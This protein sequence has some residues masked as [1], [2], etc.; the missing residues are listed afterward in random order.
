[1]PRKRPAI[2][3]SRN[4]FLSYQIQWQDFNIIITAYNGDQV[5]ELQPGMAGGNK[6]NTRP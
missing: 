2:F 4:S 3:G 6:L 5:A 1:M